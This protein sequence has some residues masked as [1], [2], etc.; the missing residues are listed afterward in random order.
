MSQLKLPHGKSQ[1]TGIRYP[2]CPARISE[3]RTTDLVLNP[4][5]LR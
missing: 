4:D 5:E 3:V 2:G 1:P